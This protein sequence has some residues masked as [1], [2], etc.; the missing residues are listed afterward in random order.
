V[1]VEIKGADMRLAA[2]AAGLGPGGGLGRLDDVVAAASAAGDAGAKAEAER[3][4]SQ[5]T[6]LQDA[7]PTAL[8]PDEIDARRR[9]LLAVLDAVEA[10]DPSLKPRAED[11]R[12][13]VLA[14]SAGESG[15]DIMNRVKQQRLADRERL[16]D[17]I[18]LRQSGIEPPSSIALLAAE[19][20]LIRD[21]IAETKVRLQDITNGP[22]AKASLSADEKAR[23]QESLDVLTAP[24][25][26]CHIVKSAAFSPVMP[27]KP[28]MTR[29]TFVHVPHLL[30]A[31]CSRC[32]EGIG[33]SKLSSDLVFK[34]VDSC[35]ECHRSRAVI[36]ECQA[37]HNYHPPAVP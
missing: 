23:K 15:A 1:D 33:K 14:L 18:D 26:K 37:C 32:H 22:K 29:A 36:S 20:R 19:Q 10:A 27:A 12:R 8:S 35:R 31:E 30:Q 9:E 4:K 16:L 3:L 13:R 28:V 21:A 11:L 5:T 7:L 6:G 17:E 2:Q 34:G 25:Q 24:C